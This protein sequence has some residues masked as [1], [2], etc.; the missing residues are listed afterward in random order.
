LHFTSSKK[1]L[2]LWLNK[3]MVSLLTN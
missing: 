1:N 2:K 3:K